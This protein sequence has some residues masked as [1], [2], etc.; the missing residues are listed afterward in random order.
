MLWIKIV[1]IGEWWLKKFL[2]N[3]FYPKKNDFGCALVIP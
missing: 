1:K 3:R 2:E